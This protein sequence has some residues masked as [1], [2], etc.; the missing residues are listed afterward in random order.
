M[1]DDQQTPADW[2]R[3]NNRKVTVS[4]F[5]EQVALLL[6]HW[7]KGL[8]HLHDPFHKRTDWSQDNYIEIVEYGELSSF[9]NDKLTRLVLLAHK[10]RIR[11]SVIGLAN[12]YTLIS[13]SPRTDKKDSIYHHHP[14]VAEMM[15]RYETQ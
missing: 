10:Y 1:S 7:V 13:F 6:N 4:P 8:Y 12:R 5:G 15:E 3:R 2:L 11:V 9:D 14:D